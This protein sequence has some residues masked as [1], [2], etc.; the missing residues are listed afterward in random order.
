MSHVSPNVWKQPLP[1]PL[2]ARVTRTSWGCVM[3]HPQLWQNKL[4]KLTETCLRFSEFTKAI[5]IVRERIWH[6]EDRSKKFSVLYWEI[7]MGK[8]AHRRKGNIRKE[9]NFGT[10]KYLK[11]Q[12]EWIHQVPGLIDKFT[13]THTL[14]NTLER[15]WNSKEKRSLYKLFHSEKINCLINY[16]ANRIRILCISSSWKL[17][18]HPQ[19]SEMNGLQLKNFLTS[20]RII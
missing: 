18:E 19:T 4:P 20:Q 10:K 3:A 5:K 8:K 7:Q 2:W 9:K 15:F 17:V 1:W 12:I 14:S 13:H 6:F 11:L 16:N